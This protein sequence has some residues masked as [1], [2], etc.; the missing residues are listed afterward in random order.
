MYI[1]EL[2]KFTFDLIDLH[3]HDL[4][5]YL[6]T[7]EKIH[8]PTFLAKYISLLRILPI[9][10][11]S[12]YRNHLQFWI[13]HENIT[14]DSN[15][16]IQALQCSLFIQDHLLARML[17]KKFK[18]QH[19]QQIIKILNVCCDLIHEDETMIA[20]LDWIMFDLI[21]RFTTLHLHVIKK[22]L[23][24]KQAHP[25]I[26]PQFSAA[27]L[28]QEIFQVTK[29][30]YYQKIEEHLCVFINKQ[31]YQTIIQPLLSLICKYEQS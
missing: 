15:A 7:V 6:I 24:C 13:N 21:R 9:H 30:N 10:N 14:V 28:C 29:Q 17:F 3:S 18:I 1:S 27:T 11:Q 20:T 16:I 26:L 31:I 4:L 8:C 2:G 12:S 5:V 25:L 19:E 22:V 23:E